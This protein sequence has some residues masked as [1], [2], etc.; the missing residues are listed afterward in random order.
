MPTGRLTEFHS[1]LAEGG[2]SMTTVAYGAVNDMGRTHAEQMYIHDE[3]MPMLENLTAS[4]HQYRCAASIQLT[5]CGYFSR[6]KQIK[7]QNPLAPS[8]RLNM[9]GTMEGLIYSKSMSEEE[10]FQTAEAFSSAASF[11]KRAGF[12]AVE[13]HMGHGYLISQFLSPTINFRTDKYGGS[14]KNRLRFPLLVLEKVR[15]AVGQDYPVLCKMNLEDGFVGGLK[16]N[17]SIEIARALEKSGA[18]ALVLSGGYTSKTPFYLMRGE[19]PLW[20]MIRAE[21]KLIQKIAMAVLGKVIIRKYRFEENFFLPLAGKIRQAVNL[22][23]VYLGGVVSADGV[24]QIMKEGFDMIAIGRALIHDP[25]FI[26]HIEKDRSHISEC[27]HCNQ[28]V[29]EMDRD[30]VRCVLVE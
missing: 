16:I 8:R 2:I 15:E 1:R 30:G 24:N 27:N 25:D 14:L 18:D 12:D 20:Q 21:R 26:S 4:V 19:V 29:A 5:H 10:I 9:Y 3:V 11:S 7:G 28:C 13:I 22:P 23:L 17:E 6:N